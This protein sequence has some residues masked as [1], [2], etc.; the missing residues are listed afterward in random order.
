MDN[1]EKRVIQDTQE[2]DKEN[3]ITTQYVLEITIQDTAK[4]I[5]KTSHRNR[6]CLTSLIWIQTH[7]WIQNLKQKKGVISI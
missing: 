2:E 7:I 4:I 5:L 3:K 6:I 1:P